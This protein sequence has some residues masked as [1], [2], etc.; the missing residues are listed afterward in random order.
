METQIISKKIKFDDKQILETKNIIFRGFE[1]KILEIHIDA[2]TSSY[3]NIYQIAI[4]KSH[5]E[6]FLIIDEN[7]TEYD[8]F[9]YTFFSSLN[10]SPTNQE[11]VL[12]MVKMDDLEIE[13]LELKHN[14]EKLQAAKDS[15]KAENNNLKIFTNNAQIENTQLKQILVKANEQLN[16]KQIE[17]EQEKLKNQINTKEE[18][19]K[20]Q[21]NNI[22]NKQEAK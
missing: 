21:K 3:E 4:F 12:S 8:H 11:F 1:N 5:W 15:L 14:I 2:Q 20:E 16:L 7:N 10:Y 18:V 22:E 13:N 17:L 19:T 9:G 6:H